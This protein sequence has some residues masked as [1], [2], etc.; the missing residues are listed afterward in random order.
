MLNAENF[1]SPVFASV[2]LSFPTISLGE[3]TYHVPDTLVC[4][5]TLGSCVIVSVNKRKIT[6]IVTSIFS[7]ADIPSEKNIKDILD[8]L[9]EDIVFSEDMIRLW[10]WS[11]SYYLT[12]P[13]EMLGTIL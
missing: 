7:S 8:I 12:S 11:S 3:L 9:E 2:A 6:G 5:I 1:S 10:K 13:G 4:K